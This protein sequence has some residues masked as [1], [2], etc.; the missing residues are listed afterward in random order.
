MQTNSSGAATV[1]TPPIKPT[2]TRGS[3]SLVPVVDGKGNRIDNIYRDPSSRDGATLVIVISMPGRK[4]HRESM[5]GTERT[6]LKAAR[7][8][9]DEIKGEVAKGSYRHP[10]RETFTAY[11]IGG[12]NAEGWLTS[13]A[14]RTSRGINR[15]TLDLYE[16]DLRRYAIPFL[17]R[18]LLGEIGPRDLRE[19]IVKLERAGLKPNTVRRIVAPVR[20]VLATA[21]GDGDI[22]FNPAAGLRMPTAERGVKKHLE[23][24]E[25]RRL[26]AEV[27]AE[28]KLLVRFMVYTGTRIGEAIEVRWSD[29]NF[30][31]GTFTI[32]RQYVERY[33]V[34]DLPKNGKSLTMR[35][36]RALL[37]DLSTLSLSRPGVGDDDLVFL[38]PRGQRI[39]Q[40]NFTNRILK[41]AARRAGL[42]WTHSHTFRHTS[43][44]NVYRL[45]GDAL[46]AQAH[47]GHHS[48]GF[49]MDN[50]VGRRATL[51]DPDAYGLD[52]LAETS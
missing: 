21:H 39:N 26:Y 1:Q 49:T 9:R 31:E 12:P 45:T 19:F 46:A 50:Y 25:L 7:R 37:A 6:D 10:V 2:T 52:L 3:R 28:W 47:L 20:A 38:S 27:P 14:G 23:D 44:T 15:R 34:V 42:D 24:D 4:Q 11:V 32:G 13:Y 35:L 36:P 16:R 51:P 33:K 17:G 40:S 41:P 43:G 48:P 8:R 22:P 30:A 29:V 5:K 18:L